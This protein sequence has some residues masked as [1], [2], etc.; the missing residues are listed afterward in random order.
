MRH[1]TTT[2]RRWKVILGTGLLAG[3]LTLSAGVPSVKAQDECQER[4]VH[5]HRMLNQAIERHGYD[6]HQANHWRHEV[7]EA[8]EYCWNHSRRWWDEDQQRWRYE[9]DW[10]DD[11][12][13]N[14]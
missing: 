12:P 6:S 10:D 4:L 14:Q 8:R 13:P 7:R 3:S 2:L 9:R 11:Y 5:A 1:S